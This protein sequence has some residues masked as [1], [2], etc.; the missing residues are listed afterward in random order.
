VLELSKADEEKLDEV[1][2]LQGAALRGVQ[3]DAEKREVSLF[4]TARHDLVEILC[5]DAGY[6]ALP[7]LFGLARPPRVVGLVVQPL[8]TDF[9]VR[10]EFSDHP[11]QVHLRCQRV[12]VRLS[13]LAVD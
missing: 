3:V 7:D 2:W 1:G 11:A 8:D 6:L 10:V 5:E 12:S 9:I 4:A 13:P